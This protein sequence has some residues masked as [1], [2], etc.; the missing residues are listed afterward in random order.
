M[1]KVT[2][3]Y[4]GILKDLSG[5][6]FETLDADTVKDVLKHIGAFWG[7]SAEK[8]ARRMVIAVNGKSILLLK[9]EKTA[10]E[11]GDVITFLPICGGG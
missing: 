8:E 10:L 9:K 3:K 2:V 7:K 11:D 6:A 5:C 4:R 1:S